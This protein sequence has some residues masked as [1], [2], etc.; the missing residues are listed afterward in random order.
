MQI[1]TEKRK[2]LIMSDFLEIFMKEKI[3]DDINKMQ[4][5]GAS[6]GLYR[7]PSDDLITKDMACWVDDA[8]TANDDDE[9]VYPEFSKNNELEFFYSGERFVDVILSVLYQVKNPSIDTLI[10]ALNY[11]DDTDDF[12]DIET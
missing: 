12:L 2:K 10:K 4:D 1:N 9:D 5:L 11:Y 6:F 3:S 8:M 7:K